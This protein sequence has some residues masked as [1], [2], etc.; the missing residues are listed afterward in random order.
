V[1]AVRRVAAGRGVSYSYSYH[2]GQDTTLALV[3]IGYA[4]GVPRQA[5]NTGPVV[6]NGSLC[7]V[8]GRIA[9]DQFVVDVGDASVRVGDRAVLFGDPAA[10]VPSADEWAQAASTINYEIVTRIGPRVA[11]RYLP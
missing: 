11:R 10:G 6:V 9:M 1:I 3:G 2:T 8:S 5:S 7:V 4:D